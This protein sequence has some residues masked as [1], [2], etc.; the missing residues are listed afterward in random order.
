[1][2]P[3]PG[4]SAPNSP[5][6]LLTLTNN[7][8]KE[9]THHTVLDTV[10]QPVNIVLTLNLTHINRV[11]A[12]EIIIHFDLRSACKAEELKSCWC[13][14]GENVFFKFLSLFFLLLFL[15]CINTHY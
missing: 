3:G 4:A 11:Y 9:V 7:C 6:A 8:E 1:M 13:F 14:Y 5:M 15:F 12:A 10:L 2:P